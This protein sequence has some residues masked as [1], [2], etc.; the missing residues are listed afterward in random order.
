[1]Y[2]GG[3]PTLQL[4]HKQR[5]VA[6]LTM[7]NHRQQTPRSMFLRTYFFVLHLHLKFRSGFIWDMVFALFTFNFN[8]SA[9]PV[10]TCHSH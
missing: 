5:T 3:I 1:M 7:I 6:I 10:I 2:H 8:R 4:Q 9:L